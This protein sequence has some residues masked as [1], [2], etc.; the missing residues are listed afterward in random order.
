[1]KAE[2]RIRRYGLEKYLK[3]CRKLDISESL[4][5]EYQNKYEFELNIGKVTRY[6]QTTW[7]MEIGKPGEVNRKGVYFSA[8][9]AEPDYQRDMDEAFRNAQKEA[10]SSGWEL[11][12]AKKIGRPRYIYHE[13]KE[14]RVEYGAPTKQTKIVES[15]Y[16]ER[17]R[18]G[19][20][21]REMGYTASETLEAIRGMK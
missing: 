5:S 15:L 4:I 1:M 13:T 17:I 6:A 16:E 2:E 9:H 20:E 11:I 21:L 7:R 19:K 14:Q 12:S 10:G 8:A 18:L 3:K